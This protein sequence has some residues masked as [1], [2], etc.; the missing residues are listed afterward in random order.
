MGHNIMQ[1]GTLTIDLH[2]KAIKN[3]YIAVLPP[4]GNVRVSAP[5][6]MSDD[7]VR[8]A[9]ASRLT[10][11]KKQQA[12]FMGQKR[13][14]KREMLSGESHYLW[15]KRYLLEVAATAG[16]HRIDLTHHKI[17]LYVRSGTSHNNKLA[18]LEQF[19]R[20]ELKREIA[21]LLPVWQDKMGV[22]AKRFG[23]KKMKTLWGSCN[24]VSGSIWLNLELAKKPP[25]CLEYVV[26]HELVHL[27]E[28]YHNARF[29]AYMDKYLPGW[30]QRKALLNNFVSE[31]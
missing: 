1:I 2:R 13:Q 5:L 12:K 10:W 18:V 24:T 28:R 22:E 19:Y 23:V 4:A 21:K 7:A 31:A 8:L 26:V 9:V 29:M 17:K 30:K 11:I 3:L 27:L 14:P 15:G 25:E 16:K 20:D 6:R